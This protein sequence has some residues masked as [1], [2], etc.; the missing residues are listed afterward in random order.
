MTTILAIETSC[1]ETSAAVVINGRKVV[2]CV[3]ASQIQLHRQYG[4][5]FPEMASREHMLAIAPVVR[6]AMAKAGVQWSDLSAIATVNGPGLAGSL[7]V[8][9]NFAKALAAAHNIPLLGIN[10]MEGH[11]YANW[12]QYEGGPETDP[13][14]P[15]VSLVVSGGHTDLILMEDH[16]QY[17][18]LGGTID[19][20]AGEAFDKVARLM[21]LGYPGGPAIERWSAG[22]DGTAFDLPR[23]LSV[24]A[25]DFSFSGL[26]TAVLRELQEL[27]RQ[28]GTEVPERGVKLA[29][30]G[31][32]EPDPNLP[33]ADLAASFQEALVDALVTKTLRALSDHS[34]VQLLVAGGV[35][36][37]SRL[38][39]ELLARAQVPVRFPPIRYCTDNAA[40][41][42]AAAH[43][44]YLAGHRATLALDVLPGLTLA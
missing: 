16:L 19:D 18:R 9:V 8:G 44:R 5:V 7:L 20:A 4:G 28:Q 31:V 40:M 30:A 34:A 37:N 14:F 10:H 13:A 15:L 12:L 11:I 3:V 22:G 33:I 24:G 29:D 1:D 39:Q 43:Y 23:A 36:A 27:Q 25:Y 35:A 32:Q 21:G 42:G 41:M 26:K 17:R 6:E 38:R 2:S